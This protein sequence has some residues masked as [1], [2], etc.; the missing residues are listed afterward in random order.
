MDWLVWL[1]DLE[2]SLWSIG[3]LIDWLIDDPTWFFFFMNVLWIF[4]VILQC[5]RVIHD[6]SGKRG[7]RR[8]LTTTPGRRARQRDLL[9][10]HITTV[11]PNLLQLAMIRR[12]RRGARAG[13]ARRRRRQIVPG[14]RMRQLDPRTG[15]LRLQSFHLRR[16]AAHFRTIGR[17]GRWGRP[18]RGWTWLCTGR[19]QRRG[20][21]RGRRKGEVGCGGRSVHAADAA[22]AAA[23][24]PEGRTFSSRL[25]AIRLSAGEYNDHLASIWP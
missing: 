23:L 16:L 3:R 11:I 5:R 20:G 8:R 4:P 17:R 10:S 25:L 1:N 19:R 14:I 6:R 7:R 18:G 2:S 22:L 12:T 13:I 24:D 9:P 21:R 15:H